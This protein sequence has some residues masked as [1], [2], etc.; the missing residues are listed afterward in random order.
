MI[1]MSLDVHALIANETNTN[2]TN[3]LKI[4]CYSLKTKKNANDIKRLEV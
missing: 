3:P 1:I 2:D 4:S